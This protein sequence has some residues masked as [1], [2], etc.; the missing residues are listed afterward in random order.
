VDLKFHQ[1]YNKILQYNPSGPC[2]QKVS[3]LITFF[4]ISFRYLT[5]SL[6]KPVSLSHGGLQL[7]KAR[8]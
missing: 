3:V 4:V 2:L 5:D 1:Y 6:F 8:S 7:K